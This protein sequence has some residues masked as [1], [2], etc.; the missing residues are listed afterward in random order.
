M[1]QATYQRPSGFSDRPSFDEQ[2]YIV[3]YCYGHHG[4]AGGY[5][6]GAD[7]VLAIFTRSDGSFSWAPIRHFNLRAEHAAEAIDAK[8]C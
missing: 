4:D 8:N 2:V 3:G 7:T 1:M 6:R 5:G